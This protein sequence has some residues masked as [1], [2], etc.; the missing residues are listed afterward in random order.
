MAAT[1]HVHRVP[2][3]S[4]AAVTRRLERIRAGD[5]QAG[6]LVVTETLFSMDSTVPDVAAL[7]AACRRFGATLLVDVAH[8]FGAIGD[9]GLGF[10]HDQAMVGQ[11]DVVMGS[12][13]K[14]FASNGGFVAS[15]AV[16]L[17][18]ALRSAAG[19]LLFSNAMSPVQASAVLAAL[20]IVRGREGAARRRRLMENVLRLRAGLAAAGFEVLGQ[21]SAIV[22]VRLGDAGT[23]RRMT[24]AALA[25]G[26]L[27]NLVEHPAVSRNNS[28]WRLQVMA[29]H[30]AEHVDRLIEVAVGARQSV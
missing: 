3:C 30:T 26:G 23:A 2:N 11:V 22:P 1:R 18:Q 13:S 5:A 16:G 9:G 12:F 17:K 19:P 15:N 28:R 4:V 24:R 10:L 8:D 20:R 25:A 29:D 14:T 21:P 6:I 27:V 7:Q